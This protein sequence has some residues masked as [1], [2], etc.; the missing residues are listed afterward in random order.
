ML[1]AGGRLRSLQ[2][3]WQRADPADVGAEDE[4]RRFSRP[5]D[6]PR[7]RFAADRRVDHALELREDVLRQRIAAGI[8]FVERQQTDAHAIGLDD[9][10][11][12]RRRGHIHSLRRDT[13]VTNDFEIADERQVVRQLYFRNLET[14]DLDAF[15]I[16]KE[17]ELLPRRATGGGG[18]SLHVR[19]IQY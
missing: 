10:M 15:A 17:V 5:D 11:L 12:E 14:L 1:A 18:Q 2:G 8:R 19:A 4:P 3:C 16:E 13:L 6:E 7:G 9:P